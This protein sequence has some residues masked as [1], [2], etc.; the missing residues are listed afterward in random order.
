MFNCFKYSEM[1]NS[2]D[3]YEDDQ[4]RGYKQIEKE[5]RLLKWKMMMRYIKL[6]IM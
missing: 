2:L 6:M 3:R 4:F 1:S 5:I